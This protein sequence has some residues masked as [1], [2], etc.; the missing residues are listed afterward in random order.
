MMITEGR[1]YR[2]RGEIVAKHR[3]M[4]EK[5]NRAVTN[6]I[7]SQNMFI[8][9]PESI[10]IKD[11]TSYERE[12]RYLVEFHTSNNCDA[13]DDQILHSIKQT[14]MECHKDILGIG[15]GSYV[16]R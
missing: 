5:L 7:F 10:E 1:E 16:T 14:I 6:A 2:F 3:H 15:V 11:I 8:Q 4:E 9:A 13:T 12:A